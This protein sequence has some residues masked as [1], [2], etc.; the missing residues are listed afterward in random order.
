MIRSSLSNGD[1]PNI[2]TDTRQ[3]PGKAGDGQIPEDKVIAIPKSIIE[4]YKIDPNFYK[5]MISAR[6]MPITCSAKVS[7]AALLQAD[8]LVN[9][10]L[11]GRPDVL[12]AMVDKNYRLIII[13]ANEEVSEVPEYFTNDPVRSAYQ[14]ERVRGYGGQNDKFRRRE[15]AVPADRPL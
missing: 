3:R 15:S 11:A 14:N 2:P 8:E 7:D 4:K 10:L 6:G 1:I 5:K 13:G 12:Q 9:K